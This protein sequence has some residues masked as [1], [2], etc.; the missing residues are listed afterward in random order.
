MCS[1]F[2][3][4]ALGRRVGLLKTGQ[5]G[6]KVNRSSPSSLIYVFNSFSTL[7]KL[8]N[9]AF[10]SSWVLVC[11]FFNQF[12]PCMSLMHFYLN[13]KKILQFFLVLDTFTIPYSGAALKSSLVK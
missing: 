2:E 9:L 5:D 1:S 12:P 7:I 6:R 10:N 8:W 4:K 13:A 11:F 3:A